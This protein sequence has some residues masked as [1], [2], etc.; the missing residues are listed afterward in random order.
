MQTLNS[1]LICIKC[2][3]FSIAH[4]KVHKVT[5]AWFTHYLQTAL[6][7]SLGYGE[8]TADI[9]QGVRERETSEL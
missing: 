7:Y 8:E 1:E 2:Q 9:S 4:S 5:G 3:L 6:H